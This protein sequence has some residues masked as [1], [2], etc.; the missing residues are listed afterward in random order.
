MSLASPKLPLAIGVAIILAV[1]AIALGGVAFNRSGKPDSVLQL[2]QRELHEPDAWQR[3]ED[4]SG[5]TLHIRWRVPIRVTD[6]DAK[7]WQRISYGG[8]AREPDWL[9]ADKLALLGFDVRPPTPSM[10]D[11]VTGNN[12]PESRREVFLALELDGP[13]YRQSLEQVRR[14]TAKAGADIEQAKSALLKEEQDSTRLFAVDAGV[15]AVALRARYPDRA[16]YAIVRGTIRPRWSRERSVSTL[17]ASID[18]LSVEEINVPRA[19]QPVFQNAAGQVASYDDGKRAPF[20][21]VVAFGRRQEPWLVQ[22]RKGGTN[23]PR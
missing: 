15:D 10:D 3:G 4:S 11:P 13:A 21:A 8:Y 16:H 14:L 12:H 5:V 19:V 17:S 20:E 22:A 1:N 7:A 6:D 2:S 18:E 23:P 9:D